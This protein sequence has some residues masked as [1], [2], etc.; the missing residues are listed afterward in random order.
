MDWERMTGEPAKAYALFRVYRDHPA[1]TRTV[2]VIAETPE[3][4]G[5]RARQ[6]RNLYARWNWAE[7]A[8]A[9]DDECAR[10]EDS[11][12]LDS[13]REMHA[14][15]SKAAR[16]MIIKA[17]QRIQVAES[18]ELPLGAAVRMLEVGTKLERSMLTTSV[19]ELQGLDEDR[20]DDAWEK[21][22]R[23]LDPALAP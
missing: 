7:R 9:W 23:E 18:D 21:I 4:G 8:A 12:R 22:A 3:V 11:Q 19:A 13:I 17:L 5:L 20:G 14:M 15:H 6:M 1:A 16:V 10:I 2:D